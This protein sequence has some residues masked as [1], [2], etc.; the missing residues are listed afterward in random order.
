[1]GNDEH[2]PVEI[3]E[4]DPDKAVARI[5]RAVDFLGKLRGILKEGEDY[6]QHPGY[7]KPALE[8]PG[9]EKIAASLNCGPE[10]LRGET[11]N[12]IDEKYGL[13][14][15]S[16]VIGLVNRS[17]GACYGQGVGYGRATEKDLY[18]W[19]KDAGRQ[20]LK[21]E[22]VEWANNTALKMAFKSGLICAALSV[23][24]LSGYFTQDLE[25]APKKPKKE[26]EN[27][28]L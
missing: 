23:G 18:A 1:M 20:V 15:F 14:E 21:P 13:K 7:P 2:L 6:N 5:N 19:D 27:V 4:F 3:E 22:R 25:K 10:I 8:K 28:Q 24:A 11:G 17:T 16:L 9:A 26:K 12:V